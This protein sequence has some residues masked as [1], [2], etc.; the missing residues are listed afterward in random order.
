M[1]AAQGY[2][3]YQSYLSFNEQWVAGEYFD[4]GAFLGAALVDGAILMYLLLLAGAIND[5][6]NAGGIQ[7][8]MNF[9]SN[10]AR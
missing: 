1:G 7:A 3:A 8:W 9:R 5:A 4:A 10:Y 6:A 2:A